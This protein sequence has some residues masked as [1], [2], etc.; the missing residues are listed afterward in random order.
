M[1]SNID[2]SEYRLANA[3]SPNLQLLLAHRVS[4]KERVNVWQQHEQAIFDVYG[5]NQNA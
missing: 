3:I 5:D 4:K 1:G 2:L